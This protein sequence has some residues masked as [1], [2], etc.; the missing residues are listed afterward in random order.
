MYLHYLLFSQEVVSTGAQN[1]K[2]SFF[3]KTFNETFKHTPIIGDWE[4]CNGF[5]QTLFTSDEATAIVLAEKILVALSE[6]GTSSAT[7]SLAPRNGQLRIDL[8][9]YAKNLNDVMHPLKER[10]D[11]SEVK[12]SFKPHQYPKIIT[13]TMPISSGNKGDMIV[14]AQDILSTIDTTLVRRQNIE[15]SYYPGNPWWT[16]TLYDLNEERLRTLAA[17]GAPSTKRKL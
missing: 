1:E 15:H 6:A 5:V 2:W 17:S 9:P 14:A 8:T 10:Y 4:C 7:V 16:K 3:I 12:I 11:G 13:A